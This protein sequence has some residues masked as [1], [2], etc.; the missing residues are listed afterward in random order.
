YRILAW[1]YM[2]RLPN[3]TAA[4]EQLM[5]KGS[6]ATTA[7]LR[8]LYPIQNTRLFRRLERVLSALANWCPVYGEA[9]SIVPALVFPFVKVCVNNDVVAFEVVL[10][11]LL[12][13]GRDFVLQ[14]PYPPRPQLTRLDAALQKRD[15]QLHAH[16]TS[17]RITPEY[18][19]SLV[20]T[21]FSEVL[22]RD[23]WLCLWDNL[24]A[25]WD[26]PSLLWAA[27]LAYLTEN[28]ANLLQQSTA[29]GIQAA[30]HQQQPMQVKRWIATMHAITLPDIIDQTQ[31]DE[32]Y[33][34][35]PPGQYPAFTRYPTFVVDYQIQERNR[36]ATDEAALESKRRLLSE[37]EART[38]ELEAAHTQWMQDK[39]LLLESE[40]RRRV[41]AMQAE[42]ARLMEMTIL[43][44]QTRDRRLQQVHQNQ[45]IALM[46]QNAKEALRETSKVLQAEHD[47]WL[48]EL[49]VRSDKEKWQSQHQMDEEELTRLEMD[50]QRR[51]AD[52]TKDRER[53]ERLQTMRLEFFAQLREQELCDQMVFDGWK[54]EDKQ[55]IA[56]EV[57]RQEKKAAKQVRREEAKLRHEWR[58]KL[59][60][61]RMQKQRQMQLLAQDRAMRRQRRPPQE[62]SDGT[63]SDES[64]EDEQQDGF[65]ATIRFPNQRPMPPPP[66]SPSQPTADMSP[67]MSA[68]T[69][70]TPKP[71]EP[72]VVQR[73]DNVANP[74]DA[75]KL[76]SPPTRRRRQRPSILGSSRASSLKWSDHE[77]LQRAL[78]DISSEEEEGGGNALSTSHRHVTPPRLSQLE[79]DLRAEFSDLSDDSLQQRPLSELERDLDE[80]LGT[81]DDEGGGATGDVAASS[82][83]TST[84]GESLLG[85]GGEDPP[86]V[87]QG[88]APTPPPKYAKQASD[89]TRKLQQLRSKLSDLEAMATKAIPAEVE[90]KLDTEMSG[91]GDDTKHE[92]IMLMERAKEL[93]EQHAAARLNR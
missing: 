4:L 51:V 56:A 63:A 84:A 31:V 34:P 62:D 11:V 60:E 20:S 25:Y 54:A 70:A 55:T 33:F 12:H 3:N 43:H 68:T 75:K 64:K 21:A 37:I 88:M 83:A 17:H 77:L 44:A 87:V 38:R 5:A 47:R 79:H 42:K 48:D 76:S 66:A 45:P 49:N 30:F 71:L 27:V 29:S 86:L 9:T 89:T 6:H 41:E 72:V 91:A 13:W 58:T 35:L 18:G 16:F 7:R 40:Q 23:D 93:L 52:L 8:D 39:A 53:E 57:D 10:S 65:P 50:A 74:L 90:A 82:G 69:S 59:N 32:K 61:Q 19:W 85:Q 15:A 2:L 92:H 1:K 26:H 22:A 80:L 46:E 67:A 78:D 28:R 73:P 14:Y 36:I 24:I 81:S